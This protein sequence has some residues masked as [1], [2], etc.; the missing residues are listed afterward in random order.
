MKASKFFSMAMAA[1]FI[2]FLTTENLFAAPSSSVNWSKQIITVTGTGFAPE[3]VYNPSRAKLLAKRAAI[4]E[5]YR[6]L[7][8]VVSGVK[9]TGETTVSEM[10]L[11]SDIIKTRVE[12]TIK[13]AQ[14]IS[15]RETADG[16]YEVTIQMPLF[17]KANSLAGVILEKPEQKISF[18][19]P[20][21]NVAPTIPAYTSATPIKQRIDIVI[22]VPRNSAVAINTVPRSSDYSSVELVNLAES[23]LP[24]VYQ[25]PVLQPP[26]ITPPT[27]P[28]IRVP[29]YPQL[30]PPTQP[31]IATPTIPQ[32]QS[33]STRTVQP[34]EEKSDITEKAAV[35]GYTGL[36]VDCREME[37]QPVMSPTIQ[38]ET[39]DTIYGDKNL[40]YD[41][42]IEFGM[43]SYATEIDDVVT[44]RAG[45]NPLVVKAV[46]LKK[47]SSSPVLTDADANRILIENKVNSFLDKLNVVFMM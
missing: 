25:P 35:G 24:G 44:D 21:P 33:P 41:K 7:A 45:K 38:N 37:L 40:D 13:G 4:N 15:E 26:Q 19:A 32:P 10:A 8:E 2:L 27:G 20:V 1:V 42:I 39:G 12:A 5:A 46:E 36:I 11:V 43:V 22:R 6:Q 18:P 9:V 29:S 34:V 17:G 3:D 30:Q 14:Q 31:Q 47:F 23:Y 16:G 28:Q